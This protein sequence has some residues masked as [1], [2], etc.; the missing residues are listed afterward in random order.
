MSDRQVMNRPRAYSGHG[1]VSSLR[2]ASVH[3]VLYRRWLNE[4]WSGRCTAAEL[5]SDDFV[6]HWPNRDVHGPAELQSVVDET[7][8]TLKELQFVLD[9]GPFQEG[10]LVGARWIGTGS[11]D[12]GPARYTGNDMMRI[13]NGKIVEYWN[14]TARG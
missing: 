12:G 10:D 13:A 11:T 8:A 9:V 14:G 3:K 2:P 7:L 6:G 4:L 1:N 5:V